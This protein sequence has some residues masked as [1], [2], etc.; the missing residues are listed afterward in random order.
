[1]GLSNGKTFGKPLGYNSNIRAYDRMKYTY[2][3]A[4][5]SAKVYI[6]IKNATLQQICVKSQINDK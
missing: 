2:Y 6:I 4:K 3:D 1:M 5:I